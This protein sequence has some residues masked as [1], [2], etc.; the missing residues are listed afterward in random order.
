MRNARTYFARKPDI[1]VQI[2]RRIWSECI[3]STQLKIKNGIDPYSLSFP[4]LQNKVSRPFQLQLISYGSLID[5]GAA[6]MSMI[7]VN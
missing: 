4:S 7:Y 6:G 2:S 3:K 5:M 1:I